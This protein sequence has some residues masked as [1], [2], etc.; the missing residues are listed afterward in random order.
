MCL[1][2]P[3]TANEAHDISCMEHMWVD[4]VGG[5]PFGD[6]LSR[7]ATDRWEL[8]PDDCVGVD[9]PMV[10]HLLIP[11]VEMSTGEGGELVGR[12]G[13]GWEEAGWLQCWQL[14]PLEHLLFPLVR[15]SM[16]V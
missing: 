11:M 13:V 12:R 15:V 2:S 3:Q 9:C 5:R 6:R 4:T 16:G 8:Y 10:E 7:I 14:R 1:N